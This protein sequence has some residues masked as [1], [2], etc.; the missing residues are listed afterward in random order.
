MIDWTKSMQH[1]FEYYVVD[2]STWK[3]S[4]RITTVKS[5]SVD[6]DSEA[7]TLGSASFNISEPVGECYIR[8]YLIAI[9]NGVREKI[10]L[11]THLVQTPSTSFDGKSTSIS[12]DAYT[13]LLEL[14][15]VPMPIG[16]YIPKDTNIMDMAYKLTS[17]NARAPV[18]KTTDS[19]NLSTDFVADTSDTYLAYTTDLM[20]NAR[21]TYD[22]DEMGRILFSPMQDTASLSPIWTYN[23]DNSSIL[24]PDI[25][26]D[27]DL[28]GIPNTVE[29]IFSDNGRYLYAKK[30]NNDPNSPVSTVNRGREIPHRVTNPDLLGGVTQDLLNRYAD[31]LL[32]E[33]STL[34]YTVDYTHGYCPVRVGDCVMLNYSRAGLTNIKAKVIKQSIKCEPGCPVTEKAVFTTKLWG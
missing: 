21:Y 24:H 1:T 20:A 18:V 28:Y 5:S 17:E 12:M 13:P 29:V 26:L 11:G 27:R 34:E 7:E 16:Y 15:D 23:D 33:L 31:Q 4:K 14:K 30:V 6:R 22:L 8:T 32:R 2:P 3:D 19:T 25:S 9:Q 10:A